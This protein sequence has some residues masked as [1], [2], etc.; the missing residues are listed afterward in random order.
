[1]NLAKL[2]DHLLEVGPYNQPSTPI[3]QE[4]TV[5][6]LGKEDTKSSTPKAPEQAREDEEPKEDKEHIED[7]DPDK[8]PME[9]MTLRRNPCRP[10]GRTHRG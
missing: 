5:L 2:V 10:Q 9:D 4:E 8:E 3:T 1:M 7:V 6:S